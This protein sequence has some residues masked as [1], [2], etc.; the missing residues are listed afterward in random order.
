V[1]NAW[2]KAT[3]GGDKVLAAFHETLAQ[4]KACQ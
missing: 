4:V 1:T 3:L 2:I